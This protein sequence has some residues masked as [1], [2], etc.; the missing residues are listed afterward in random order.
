MR[1]NLL[2]PP[3]LGRYANYHTCLVPPLQHTRDAV[4]M[5]RHNVGLLLILLFTPAWSLAAEAIPNADF[6]QG[7]SSPSGWSLSEGNGRW[8]DRHVLEV[9]GNGEDSTRW[10]SEPVALKPGGLYRFQTR[11]RLA[12]GTGLATVGPE[13]ANRDVEQLTKEWQW[14][15]H[16][17]CVPDGRE[18]VRF[19]VGQWHSNGTLQFDAA[20]LA[21]VMPIYRKFG[22]L[23]LGD[24]ES[25]RGGRYVF[26]G[27]F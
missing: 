12:R 2:F 15:D 1:Q 26:D 10:R 18:S 6:D 27:S 11:A 7:D 14:F 4:M 16:V 19:H 25:I 23:R 24:G 3:G 21:T 13:F 5:P 8:L 20:R 17:F 22:T 9:A